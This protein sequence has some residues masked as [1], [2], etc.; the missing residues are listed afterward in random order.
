MMPGKFCFIRTKVRKYANSKH[1]CLSSYHASG[2]IL[3]INESITEPWAY[4]L[5]LS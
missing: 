4:T 5:S 3:F 1:R 2:A